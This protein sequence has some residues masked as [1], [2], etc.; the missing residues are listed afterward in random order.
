MYLWVYVM[1][2]R[3]RLWLWMGLSPSGWLSWARMRLLLLLLLLLL[4][5]AADW[6]VRWQPASTGPAAGHCWQHHWH[7]ACYVWRVLH[8]AEGLEVS[9]G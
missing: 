2:E 4:F 1:D 3:T 7:Y 9:R 5:A 6:E 8:D